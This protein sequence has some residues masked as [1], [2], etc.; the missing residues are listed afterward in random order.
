MKSL[1]LK[2]HGLLVGV[3]T[4]LQS[5]LL[6]AVRLYW[7]WGFFQTGKGKWMHLERTTTYFASLHIPAPKLNA[8]LAAGTECTGGL[9]LLLG[10][11]SR[12][13]SPALI[14]VMCVAYATADQQALRGIFT[15]PD[16]FVSADPFLFLFA[17]LLIFVF[18][19]G[20]FSLDAWIFKSGRKNR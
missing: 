6:L 14:G 20:F 5:P 19:P 10:L 9:L 18:G 8:I 16:K 11:F 7:G 2:I 1:L 15:D 12:F 4:A 13:A 17:S 3:G